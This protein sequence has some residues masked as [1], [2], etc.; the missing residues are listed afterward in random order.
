MKR[1]QSSNRTGTEWQGQHLLS[2]FAKICGLRS[3]NVSIEQYFHCSPVNLGLPPNE[4]VEKVLLTS[5]NNIFGVLT[6]HK[7][8]IVDSGTF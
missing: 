5:E 4:P 7:H 6:L 1:L 2:F 8:E 3:K